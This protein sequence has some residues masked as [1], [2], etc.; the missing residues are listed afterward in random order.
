MILHRIKF[1]KVLTK[2]VWGEYSN[3]E[4]NTLAAY[5]MNEWFEVD[6]E[7]YQQILYNM[8]NIKSQYRLIVVEE[9]QEEEHVLTVQEI[10]DQIKKDARK[11]ELDKEKRKKAQQ[12]AAATKKQKQIEKAKKLLEQEGVI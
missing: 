1:I 10:L 9:M 3:N 2:E 7:T 4:I 5:G 6:E 8:H 12:K 11:K